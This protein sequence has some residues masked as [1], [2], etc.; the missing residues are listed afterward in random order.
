M[1]WK[2]SLFVLAASM[3]VADFASAQC[4][5]TSGSRTVIR[6]PASELLWADYEAPCGVGC[7]SRLGCGG[8]CGGCGCRTGNQGCL[9]PL[10]CIVPNTL[11][12]IGRALTCLVPCGPRS[13]HGCGISCIG[14]GSGCSSCGL[15]GCGP[16]F[17]RLRSGCASGCSTCDAGYD[18]Y[19]PEYSD[20]MNS[21]FQDDPIPAPKPA[22]APPAEARRPAARTQSFVTPPKTLP[23]PSH[24][25]VTRKPANLTPVRQAST[26]ARVP[27]GGKVTP[28]Q[29]T[30]AKR[31]ASVLKR[32]SLEES[33]V[34]ETSFEP[35]P[36]P[37]AK[38]T[39]TNSGIPHNPLR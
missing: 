35:A 34:E 21:P 3:F 18:S 13:G 39:A 31:E 33:D 4:G 7:G 10:R 19:T 32:A 25:T 23:T 2:I 29:H 9:P 36:V 12:T 27:A 6:K 16:W 28:V 22:P 37:S 5:C 30:V 8:G 14:A 1:N 26:L 20:A 24:A 11:R 17:P 15:G 38:R